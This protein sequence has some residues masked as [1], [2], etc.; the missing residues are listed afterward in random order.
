MKR[1]ISVFKW[2]LND[3]A[4][5][6]YEFAYNE[7]ENLRSEYESL[8]DTMAQAMLDAQELRN[9]I[10]DNA[11]EVIDYTLNLKVQLSNEVMTALTAL[12]DSLGDAADKATD[13]IATLG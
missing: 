1:I 2:D 4:K 7:S 8:E 9:K 6:N 11:L 5:E 13:R 3:L 12:L 10:Y